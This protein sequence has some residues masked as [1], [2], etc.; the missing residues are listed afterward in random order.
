MQQR[1]VF[2]ATV[3][4]V[5][6]TV[7]AGILGIPYVVQK[8]GFLTGIFSLVLVAFLLLMN[9][10]YLGEVVLRTKGY[11]Q[12]PG[13]AEKY[14]GF[15]GKLLMSLAFILEGYGALAAYFVGFGKVFTV[16]FGGNPLFY[17]ILLFLVFSALL[18]FGLKV[19]S[20]SENVLVT[21]LLLSVLALFLLGFSSF[22]FERLTE[23]SLGKILL[24]Y[25]VLL[26]AFL[27]SPA[28]PEL[29]KEVKYKKDLRKA[30]VYGVLLV[31]V[32]Y[33][34]FT[35]IMV[36][37]FG[38]RVE[39][40]ATMSLGNLSFFALVLGN[41]FAFL[42]MGTS[43]LALG[44]TLK[45]MFILDFSL[46]HLLAWFLAL[47]PAFFLGI[48]GLSFIQILQITGVFAG[49]LTLFLILV[50]HSKAKT[51]GER[52][53]EYSIPDSFFLKAVFTLIILL[54]VVLMIF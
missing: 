8:A 40:L 19:M 37:L 6:M 28:I 11:H 51:Q 54:G 45:D 12:L 21:L 36:G 31:A 53:P 32:I 33:V 26:F 16:I 22:S 38:S 52:K 47:V 18:Y 29:A 43:F 14:L 30:I 10:L 39:E 5:G 41:L 48:S 34:L 25:G 35:F 42:T 27:G 2:T 17:S 23:F 44:F 9:H 49:G 4:L 50:M 24:P 20:Q 15:H 46:K 7:G 1:G 3:T 13:L